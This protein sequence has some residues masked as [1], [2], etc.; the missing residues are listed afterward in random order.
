MNGV[1]IKLWEKKKAV[2]NTMLI[3]GPKD[4]YISFVDKEI[5]NLFEIV[6]DKCS[7]NKGLKDESSMRRKVY[8]N[9]TIICSL[10]NFEGNKVRMKIHITTTHTNSKRKSIKSRRVVLPRKSKDIGMIRYTEEDENCD[11][12]S[13]DDGADEN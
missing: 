7:R 4:K 13:D 11:E 5:T 9:R 6:L 2:K 12:M 8:S 10:C 3:D 1:S